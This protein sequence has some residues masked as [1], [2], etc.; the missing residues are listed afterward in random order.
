MTEKLE[1]LSYTS[2]LCGYKGVLAP[3]GLGS[4]D[5][6]TRTHTHVLPHAHTEGS[7]TL[8][9]TGVGVGEQWLGSQTTLSL[10]SF[11]LSHPLA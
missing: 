5:C 2:D 7:R 3:Q 6:N 9:Q 1:M 10:C 4:G 11:G 8:L